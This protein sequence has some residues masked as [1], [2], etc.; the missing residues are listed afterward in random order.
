MP[1]GK[2]TIVKASFGQAFKVPSLN[3]L[4]NPNVGNPHLQ[5]EKVNGMDA[6]VQHRFGERIVV[7]GTYYYNMFLI[8][9][10]SARSRFAW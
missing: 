6:G 4:G 5:P 3:T 1:A 10:T 7:S 9:S 2:R 8:S